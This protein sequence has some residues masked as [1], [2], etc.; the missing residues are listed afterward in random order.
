MPNI[1][2]L[3]KIAIDKGIKTDPR[4]K[5]QIQEI[6]DKEKKSF[7][8]L[9]KEEKEFYDRER[10]ENPFL[11]SRIFFAGQKN[12]S[13]KSLMVGIDTE[14]PEILLASE[15]KRNNQ[16]IDA[17][18]GHHP[19]NRALLNLAQV[20]D[21]QNNVT[22]KLG[23]SINIAEKILAPRLA[24][25]D[26]SVN[27]ANAFRSERA[28]KLLDIPFFNVH[29]PADN[30]AFVFME[31]NICNKNFKNLGEVI[32]AI[33]NIPEF[34]EASKMGNPPKIFCGSEKSRPGKIAATGF[35][36]GTSGSCKIYEKL[37]LAGVGTVLEM[38]MSEA[39]RKEAEKHHL[40]VI[41]CSHMASDS[42]GMN[43][44]CDLYEKKGVKIIPISGFIRVKRR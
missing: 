44:I 34:K 8:K 42:L 13:I 32:K 31:K 40:N 20:M 30:C 5:K 35:T 22:E 15:L 27:A 21:I 38:H 12:K 3:F 6:L 39:H 26:R 7:K 29:T 18:M 10:M 4:S 41:I 2:E 25:V 37:S 36:G 17:L 23:V 28:A 43:Q 14:T 1:Q 16:K 33:K 9:S 24:E 11:D 19:E